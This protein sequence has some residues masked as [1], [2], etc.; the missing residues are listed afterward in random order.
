MN[1]V[2]IAIGSN[3]G[4]RQSHLEFAVRRLQG[5]LTDARAS[6]FY[7]TE[8]HDVGPQP[9]FL[10]GAVVGETTEAAR[11]LLAQLLSL[12]RARGRTRPYAGAPRTLDLDLIFYGDSVIDE[13]GLRVPHP[14]FRERVFVL[15]PL[16]EVAGEWVDPQT[17]VTVE[18][19]LRRLK[20]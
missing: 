19:L 8:P 2:A 9:R 4:D 1:S 3:L 10:N 6:G 11:T 20:N 7:D 5:L 13:P 18:E 17:G 12:E 16:A 14:R 15:E